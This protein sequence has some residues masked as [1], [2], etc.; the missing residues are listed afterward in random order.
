MPIAVI[1]LLIIFLA[2][3]FRKISRVHIPIWSI[4][5]VGAIATLL[6]QQITPLKAIASI[7][8]DVMFYLLGVFL[9]SQAAE[10]SG[11]LEQLTDRIFCH[12]HTGREA[13]LIIT[14]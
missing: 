13:L 6:F 9:I 8:P 1:I 5:T 2:I 3:A 4:T 12:A 10:E 7:E 11:Y 14:C